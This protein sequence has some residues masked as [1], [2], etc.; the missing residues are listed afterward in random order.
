MEELVPNLLLVEE[1][2][3]TSRGFLGKAYFG[4]DEIGFA[5]IALGTMFPFIIVTQKVT[6]TVFII[7][8]TMPFLRAWM[9]QFFEVDGL[10]LIMPDPAELLE[11]VTRA[12]FTSLSVSN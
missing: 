4:G 11:Y 9:E 7:R 5:H 1:A 12:R 6:N 8:E 2:L 3:R 10:K